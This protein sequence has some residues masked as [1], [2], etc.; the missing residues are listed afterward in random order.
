MKTARDYWCAPTRIWKNGC[1]TV[2]R[3]RWSFDTVSASAGSLRLTGWADRSSTAPS[4]FGFIDGQGQRRAPMCQLVRR[5]SGAGT[6]HGFDITSPKPPQVH[7]RLCLWSR[8]ERSLAVEPSPCPVR[9]MGC[10]SFDSIQA[11][12][13][14]IRLTGWAYDSA[15]I[16][17]S[18]LDKCRWQGGPYQRQTH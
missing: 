12:N 2:V 14:E 5:G 11:V 15:T 17:P 3:S 13:A 6:N 9:W 16:N 4:T 10:G 1:Q 7:T 18:Y 8:N